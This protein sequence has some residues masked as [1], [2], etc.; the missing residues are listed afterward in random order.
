[1]RTFSNII[2][3][4]A[5]VMVMAAVVNIIHQAWEWVI[6]LCFGSITFYFGL[7]IRPRRTI[8]GKQNLN[9]TT[10]E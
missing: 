6:T 9:L 7:Y 10:D 5:A 4:L 8:K 1:M 3:F 2:I